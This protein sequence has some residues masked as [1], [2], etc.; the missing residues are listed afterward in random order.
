[1]EPQSGTPQFAVR[2]NLVWDFF[3]FFPGLFSAKMQ[4]LFA[5]LK[6]NQSFLFEKRYEELFC[7]PKKKKKLYF[8]SLCIQQLVVLMDNIFGDFLF[9]KKILILKKI[10]IPVEILFHFSYSQRQISIALSYLLF[11]SKLFSYLLQW[12]HTSRFL[13]AVIMA[14]CIYNWLHATLRIWIKT[15]IIWR[16]QRYNCS[17]DGITYILCIWYINSW[18]RHKWI[19]HCEA[20]NSLEQ[21]FKVHV[22]LFFTPVECPWENIVHNS[23]DFL[24]SFR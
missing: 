19:N 6:Q 2:S 17:M 14:V 22:L 20:S 23:T 13:Y 24:C 16:I 4:D 11:D 21:R 10:K 7:T 12:K 1:M 3:F 8:L 9:A 15:R 5:K 18:W